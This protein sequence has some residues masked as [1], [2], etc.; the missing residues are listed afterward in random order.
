MITRYVLYISTKDLPNGQPRCMTLVFLSSGGNN[1]PLIDG[2]S[3]HRLTNVFEGKGS[4]NTPSADAHVFVVTP[5]SY[6]EWLVKAEALLPR[7]SWK[8]GGETNE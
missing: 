2:R 8:T 7:S 1:V 3:T 5:T 6:N 4:H